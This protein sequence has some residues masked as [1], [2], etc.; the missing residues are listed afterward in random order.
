MFELNITPKSIY[1]IFVDKSIVIKKLYA[2]VY[3][4]YKDDKLLPFVL[5]LYH[6]KYYLNSEI[7]AL[8]K[9]NQPKILCHSNTGL[10]YIIM[11]RIPGMDLYSYVEKYG[12]FC[13]DDI[14][15]IA[16]NIL[17]NLHVLHKNDIIHCDIKPDNIIYDEDTSKITIIDFEGRQT[18]L[19]HSPEQVKDL[20]V[21]TKTDIWSFGITLY[22]LITSRMPF[23]TDFEVK[24]CKVKFPPFWSSQL[25]HF[26]TAV[27]EKDPDKR[28]SAKK[29]L[30]H[31]WF[32]L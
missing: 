20:E 19:Y 8:T 29:A 27:L 24:T 4:L 12:Y 17:K 23:K 11:S 10:L 1:D 25:K 26:L 2:D 3:S 15:P 21:T 7:D 30:K 9:V 16:K 31:P 22:S 6:E 18:E 28:P 32:K 13:E 5:K 14:K